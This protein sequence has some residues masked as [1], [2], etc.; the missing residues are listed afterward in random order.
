MIDFMSFF[1]VCKP[2]LGLFES[3]RILEIM[4][5]EVTVDNLDL[6]TPG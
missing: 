5:T 6:L 3:F 4:R 2:F 1:P